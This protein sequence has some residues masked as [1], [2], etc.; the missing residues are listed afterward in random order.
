MSNRNRNR[1]RN[2]NAATQKTD[3]K[4]TEGAATVGTAA[5]ITNTSGDDAEA[6][7]GQLAQ[8][9]TGGDATAVATS[10]E[11]GAAAPV[12]GDSATPED[13]EKGSAVAAGGGQAVEAAAGM[14]TTHATDAA[15]TS[16]KPPIIE[17]ETSL[18]EILTPTVI[19]NTTVKPPGWIEMTDAEAKPYQD[20][21]V[22][23]TERC[24]PPSQ[25]AE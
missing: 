5:A 21:G 14:A 13:G 24:V 19:R 1:N 15:I 22:L 16:E 25:D 2:A 18:F 9:A 3:M 4:A 10:T 17:D 6:G 20:A 23:G 12:G 11:P 7:G 8:A